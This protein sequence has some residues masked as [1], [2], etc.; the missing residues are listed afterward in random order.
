MFDMNFTSDFLSIFGP[1][2]MLAG[3]IPFQKHSVVSQSILRIYSIYSRPY[4]RP[5]NTALTMS[6]QCQHFCRYAY[7]SRTYPGILKPLSPQRRY[8]HVDFKCSIKDTLVLRTSLFSW[9]VHIAKLYVKSDLK[10][11]ILLTLSLFSI[12][13]RLR[14]VTYARTFSAFALFHSYPLW[15]FVLHTNS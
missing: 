6:E 4:Q 9:Y 3:L 5:P 8:P 13:H 12:F 15:Y 10:L 1:T 14:F 2:S 7:W 11:H